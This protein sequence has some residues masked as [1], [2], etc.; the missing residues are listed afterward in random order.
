[1]RHWDEAALGLGN[2]VALKDWKLEWY[3]GLVGGPRFANLYRAHQTVTKEF[4]EG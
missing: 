1:M 4:I 3:S 2:H